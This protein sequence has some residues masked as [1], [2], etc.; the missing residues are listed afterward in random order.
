MISNPKSG[1]CDFQLGDFKGT[2][3]YLTDVPI[4]LLNAFIDYYTKGYGVAVF[5]EE[6]SF[7]TLIITSYNLGIF[8]IEEK[9]SSILHD[10]SDFQIED[11]E[12]E[13]IEDIEKDLLGWTKFIVGNTPEEFA[14]HQNNI[15]LKIAQLKTIIGGEAGEI[16]R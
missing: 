9:D 6:G 11:L 10:F 3:S 2:P 14:E 8:I 13:L 4:N 7:F 16:Y 15:K 1:W 5:D 12:E